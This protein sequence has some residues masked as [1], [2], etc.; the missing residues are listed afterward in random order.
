MVEK[1]IDVSFEE[2]LTDQEKRDQRDLHR[3]VGGLVKA[4]DA[5]EVL[6]DGLLL[7]EVV[8]QLEQIVRSKATK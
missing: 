6:T 4:N 1:G 2:V 3:S 7:S 8:D 5:V